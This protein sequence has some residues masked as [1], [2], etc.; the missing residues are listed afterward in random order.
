[1]SA[2]LGIYAFRPPDAEWTKMKA[3]WD[4]CQAAAVEIPAEVSDFF[5]GEEPDPAGVL[6]DL[7]PVLKPRGGPYCETGCEL[8]VADIPAGVQ[9][10]RFVLER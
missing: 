3:V 1:M 6:V 4:A 2:T 9:T 5:N 10:L 7:Q 8:A